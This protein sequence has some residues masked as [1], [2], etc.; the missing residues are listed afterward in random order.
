MVSNEGSILIFY[1][2]FSLKTLSYIE[3]ADLKCRI[4]DFR[5]SSNAGYVCLMTED[6]ACY[7]QA[8]S[9]GEMPRWESFA[10]AHK[11]SEAYTAFS[12]DFVDK[13]VLDDK[14]GL[15]VFVGG[16]KSKYMVLYE[17]FG[18]KLLA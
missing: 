16:T 2:P 12:F 13:E 8:V 10:P 1:E 4:V 6:N 18:R 17:D 9:I 3:P 11:Q 7:F 5:I 15:N 14:K